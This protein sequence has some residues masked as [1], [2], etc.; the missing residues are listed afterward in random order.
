MNTITIILLI[1]A[2]ICFSGIV[3]ADN[4]INKKLVKC[5]NPRTWDIIAK[6]TCL[7]GFICNLL[8]AHMCNI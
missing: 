6:Y 3:I 1:S 8:S 5:E 2:L 4:N 7:L